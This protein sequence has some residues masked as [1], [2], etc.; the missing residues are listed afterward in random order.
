MFGGG[1]WTI[2]GFSQGNFLNWLEFIQAPLQNAGQVETDDRKLEGKAG[3]EWKGK[4]ERKTRTEKLTETGNG[5]QLLYGL[6]RLD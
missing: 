5:R 1:E 2:A 3:T 4:L 6:A